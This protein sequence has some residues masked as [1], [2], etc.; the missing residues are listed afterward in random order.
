MLGLAA[1]VTVLNPKNLVRERERRDNGEEASVVSAAQQLS[2]AVFDAGIAS[3]TATR[4]ASAPALAARMSAASHPSGVKP[5]AVRALGPFR[6]FGWSRH[7]SMRRT[8][9]RHFPTGTQ[10]AVRAP[11]RNGCDRPLPDP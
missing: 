5:G 1:G 8:H 7:S 4:A 3:A 10:P 11:R 2:C 9:D 6:P